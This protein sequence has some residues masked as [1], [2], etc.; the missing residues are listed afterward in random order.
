[1]AKWLDDQDDTPPPVPRPEAEFLVPCLTLLAHPD[2]RRIGEQ[3]L[4]LGFGEGA[5][6]QLSPTTPEFA[7]LDG[8]AYRGLGGEDPSAWFKI[9]GVPGAL[10]LVATRDD[11]EVEVDGRPLMEPRRVTADELAEG[12]VILIQRQ[13]TLVLHWQDPSPER[14]KGY[15]LMGEG[16]AMLRVRREIERLARLRFNVLLHGEPGVGKEMVARAIHKESVRTDMPFFCLRMMHTEP[17]EVAPLLFG[18]AGQVDGSVASRRGLFLQADGGTLFLDQVG[19]TP[20]DVHAALLRTLESR[21]IL[22]IG[23]RGS[24]E[25]DVRVIATT[26]VEALPLTLENRSRGAL[27]HRL[28][29]Y[30]LFVPALRQRREDL[31]RLFM[32]CL[33]EHLPTADDGESPSVSAELLYRLALEPWPG[34][35]PQLGRFVER[36]ADQTPPNEALALPADLSPL[37]A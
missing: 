14:P 5:E 32:H 34:N 27:L 17:N 29:G 36:L 28:G 13:L 26:E 15:G 11:V 1:M 22:P 20:Q 12:V 30:G 33:A 25:V 16:P 4:L 18:A 7:S 23:G 9:L 10:S 19:E 24:V 3:S 8:G 37:M 6:L 21:E 35:L 2:S 31:G